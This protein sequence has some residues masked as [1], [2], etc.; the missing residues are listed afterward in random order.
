MN[1]ELRLIKVFGINDS[2]R[3]ASFFFPHI[4]IRNS[5]HSTHSQTQTHEKRTTK[6]GCNEK[7]QQLQYTKNKKINAH[8]VSVVVLSVPACLLWALYLCLVCVRECAC[9][10]CVFTVELRGSSCL[11]FVHANESLFFKKREDPVGCGPWWN[12][13]APAPLPRRP[14]A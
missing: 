14:A 7:Q 1:A 6:A 3:S 10:V 8:P 2:Q 11:F 5:F 13:T 9:V 12:N 4:H